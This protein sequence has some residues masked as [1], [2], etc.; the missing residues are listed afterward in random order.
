MAEMGMEAIFF[1]RMNIMKFNELKS[2]GDLEFV[3]IPTFA[4]DKGEEKNEIL[5]HALHD[6]YNPPYFVPSSAYMTGAP[7]SKNLARSIADQWLSY[8]D[9]YLKAYKTRNIIVLWGD[10]FAH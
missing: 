4:T 3:W 1:A 9:D 6:H 5:A 10:D 2:D 7:Y 8:F